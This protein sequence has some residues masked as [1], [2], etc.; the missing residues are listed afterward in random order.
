MSNLL[1]FARIQQN[2]DFV[3]RVAAATLIRAR[4]IAG[5]ELTTG[6]RSFIT[7]VT[8]NPLVSVPDMVI[9]VATN[10]AVIGNVEIANGEADAVNVPDADIQFAVNENMFTVADKMFP[11]A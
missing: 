11:P 7:Y 2:S 6:Q 8:G 9:A 5:W 3:S 10:A 4:D 1:K